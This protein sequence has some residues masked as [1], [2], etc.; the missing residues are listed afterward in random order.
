ML[1][2]AR[3]ETSFPID[4]DSGLKDEILRREKA[5]GQELQQKG[6]VAHLWRVVGPRMANLT[7]F[8]VESNEELQDI[9]AGLPMRAYMDIDVTLIARHPS[10]VNAG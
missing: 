3:M 8:D 2:L 5:Y 7:M 10:V 9:L 4:I 6:K 1:F